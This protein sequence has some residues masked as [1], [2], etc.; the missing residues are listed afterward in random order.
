MFGCTFIDHGTSSSFGNVIS[1]EGQDGSIA[2]GAN[3]DYLYQEG[4][5][6]FVDEIGENGGTMIFKSQESKGRAVCYS[7]LTD[8]YRAIHSAFIFGAL[9]NGTN[10]KAELMTR[11]MEYFAELTGIEEYGSEQERVSFSVFPNPAK[12][13]A[14]ISFSLVRPGRV[15]AKIHNAAGQVV[16]KLA[17]GSFDAGA[18]DL[19]WNLTDSKGRGLPNGT[20]ILSLETPEDVVSKPIVILR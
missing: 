12:T 6:N 8:N 3:Y 20:Y 2:Q 16:S 5:D 15:A 17:E 19:V 1:V 10:T 14:N 9:R 4:P 13:S 11:Y 7:G 18:H